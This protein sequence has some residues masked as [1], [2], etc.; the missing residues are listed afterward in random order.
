MVSTGAGLTSVFFWGWVYSLPGYL[1]YLVA[2]EKIK[3]N[4]AEGFS[5]TTW[6]SQSRLKN[7]YSVTLQANR[8]VRHGDK[9]ILEI[10]QY[11]FFSLSLYVWGLK[12]R[13]LSDAYS[14]V[15]SLYNLRLRYIWF[16]C[17][18]MFRRVLI[19]F[20]YFFFFVECISK[21]GFLLA[22]EWRRV[23]VE[24]ESKS[25]QQKHTLVWP[26]WCCRTNHP[27]WPGA[28]PYTLSPLHTTQIS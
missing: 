9:N 11:L 20:F 3:K 26:V 24:R 21:K 19:S 18:L 6:L 12:I 10:F 17:P 4:G 7:R 13:L 5:L 16:L 15:M 8:T 23:R 14:S 2:R 28:P 27:P 25:A 22:R 1:V